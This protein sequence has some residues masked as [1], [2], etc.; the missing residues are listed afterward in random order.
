MRVIYLDKSTPREIAKEISEG[1]RENQHIGKKSIAVLQQMFFSLLNGAFSE[2]SES[3]LK[4]FND[5]W[6]SMI[7]EIKSLPDGENALNSFKQK[8]SYLGRIPPDGTPSTN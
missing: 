1:K 6:E 5:E 3:E 7:K 4:K 2:K 8:Y